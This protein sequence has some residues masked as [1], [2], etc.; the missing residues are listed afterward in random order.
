MSNFNTNLK[1]L[2]SRPQNTV[3]TAKS[4]SGSGIKHYEILRFEKNGIIK[5]LSN[6]AYSRFNENPDIFGAIYSLQTDLKQTSHIGGRTVLSIVYGKTQY[7]AEHKKEIFSNKH[8]TFPTWFKN[9]Y[10]DSYTQF[11]TDFIPA[12]ESLEEWNHDGYKMLVSSLERALLEVMYLIPNYVSSEEAFE[13]MQLATSIRPTEMQNLLENC[14]SI[15]A[16]RLLLCF[17]DLC[18]HQWFPRLNIEKIDLGSGIR[19]ITKGGKLN[20]KYNLV[21]P[22]NLESL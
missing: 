10:K 18:G 5:R 12:T 19:E 4:L 17:A 13:I 6:G 9:I 20:S 21:L 15:K 3:V 16:K 1:F 7:A 2:F 14:K 11:M 8:E 22:E